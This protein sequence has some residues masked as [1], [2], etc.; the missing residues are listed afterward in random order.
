MSDGNSPAQEAKSVPPSLAAEQPPQRGVGCTFM[1]WLLAGLVVGVIATLVVLRWQYADP[2]P[3]ISPADF[4]A[5]RDRWQ[6]NGPQNYDIEIRVTGSRGAL[7]RVE[8][9]D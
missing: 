3:Q 1:L 4:Y 2:L 9:R 5:A 7:H 6:A 8:V